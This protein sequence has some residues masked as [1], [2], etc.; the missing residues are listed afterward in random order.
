ML[1]DHILMFQMRLNFT[2]KDQ[3][4][5]GGTYVTDNNIGI[6]APPPPS[7]WYNTFII[8]LLDHSASRKAAKEPPLKVATLTIS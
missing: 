5:I 8:A 3:R 4:C 6:I 7:L 1:Q 2:T